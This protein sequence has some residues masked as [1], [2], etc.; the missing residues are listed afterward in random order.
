MIHRKIHRNLISATVVIFFI[1]VTF[2]Y[3]S[4]RGLL[5]NSNIIEVKVSYEKE[6]YIKNLS[7]KLEEKL[8]SKIDKSVWEVDLKNIKEILDNESWIKS[9]S[10]QKYIPNKIDILINPRD[11]T[12]VY[13]KKDGTTLPVSSDGVVLPKGTFT[14]TPVAPI[15]NQKKLLEKKEL[16]N[17]FLKIISEIPEHG[18]FSLETIEQIS[19]DKKQKI[20]FHVDKMKIKL[21]EQNIKKKVSRINRSIKYLKTRGIANCVIDADL[22]QKVLVR[23]NTPI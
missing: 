3:V 5:F 23:L 22:S 20:W 18:N 1:T 12:A 15:I 11:I 10:I 14:K 13:V 8:A 2:S 4:S 16:L 19:L 9:Y 17:K 21:N 6:Q 7:T